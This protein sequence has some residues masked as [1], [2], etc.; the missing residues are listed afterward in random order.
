MK[1]KISSSAARARPRTPVG[2][3]TNW[4]GK[5]QAWCR[6]Q[7]EDP[8]TPTPHHWITFDGTPR[9]AVCGDP[10]RGQPK[11]ASPPYACKA[12]ETLVERAL[13]SLDLSLSPG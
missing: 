13:L 10:L 2:V 7:A 9:C 1:P 4:E 12:H 5:L 8:Q 3:H 11:S 6:R